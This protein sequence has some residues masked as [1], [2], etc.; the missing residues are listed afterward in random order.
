V[1]TGTILGGEISK[2]KVLYTIPQNKE[3][4][5][6]KIEAYGNDVEHISQGQRAS[7]NLVNFDKDDYEKGLMLCDHLYDTTA[8][9]DVELS[10]FSDVSP[11]YKWSRVEFHTATIQTQAS[12]RLMDSNRLNPLEKCFAQVHL[13]K[14]IAV[15]FGDKFIIRNTSGTTSLGGGRVIDAFPLYHRRKT[16]RVKSLLKLRLSNSLTDIICSEVE[17]D[18]QPISIETI[19]NRLC[20]NINLDRV[21]ALP[22]QYTKHN[23]WLWLK[24]EQEKLENKITRYLQVA[25][26]A[27]PLDST[28]KS[29]EEF[30]SLIPGFPDSAKVQVLKSVID[31]LVSNEVIEK[32]GNTYALS[33]HKVLLDKNDHIKINWVDQFILNQR[34]KV[35]LLSELKE[36]CASQDIDEKRLKQ[37]LFYLIARNR[38]IYHDGEYIHRLIVDRAR[39]KLLEYLNEHPEGISVGEFRDLINGNR[40]MCILLLSIFDKEGITLRVG[41]RRKQLKDTS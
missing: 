38:L 16:D 3:I 32:R 1:V 9:I 34:M 27:N 15:C 40:K 10:L 11:L 19:S 21:G 33:T 17:K 37:I 22:E 14:E 5:I 41:D 6:R 29:H 39:I 26:K 13:D 23:N 24:S 28:G 20:K 7:L 36:R 25:H 12:I 35:P 30:V 8:L 4:K 18:I 31:A 2:N